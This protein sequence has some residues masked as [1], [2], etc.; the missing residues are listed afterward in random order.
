MFKGSKDRPRKQRN[1]VNVGE[2]IA[3]DL[4]TKPINYSKD[5]QYLKIMD[6]S[7]RAK[8]KPLFSLNDKEDLKMPFMGN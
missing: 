8:A 4:T 3:E 5:I 6:S 7:F 2:L 1:V